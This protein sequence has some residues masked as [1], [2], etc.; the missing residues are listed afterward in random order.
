MQLLFLPEI[1][2]YKVKTPFVVNSNSKFQIKHHLLDIFDPI[3]NN[4]RPIYVP[5]L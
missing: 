4:L 5:Y 1:R 2:E 3:F